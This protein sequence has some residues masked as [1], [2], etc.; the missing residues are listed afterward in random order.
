MTM[1][2]VAHKII[3][4]LKSDKF[5]N[6]QKHLLTSQLNHPKNHFLK[7]FTKKIKPLTFFT[8]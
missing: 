6:N 5:A 7:K 2:F 8:T 3:S 1:N 4:Q